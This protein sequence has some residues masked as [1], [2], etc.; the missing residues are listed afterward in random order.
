MGSDSDK[1]DGENRLLPVALKI[2]SSKWKETDMN[3][4]TKEFLFSEVLSK[5]LGR[6]LAT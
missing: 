4:F 2:V 6:A 5:L 1:P 3:G